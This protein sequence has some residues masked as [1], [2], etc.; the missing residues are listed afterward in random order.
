MWI[1]CITL[2]RRTLLSWSIVCFHLLIG[3]VC[4]GDVR[5]ALSENSS[6]LNGG[7]LKSVETRFSAGLYGAQI[8]WVPET[9]TLCIE[10]QLC[11]F[12]KGYWIFPFT[13]VSIVIFFLFSFK[14]PLKWLTSWSNE[15]TS[16]CTPMNIL[17][18]LFFLSPMHVMT[19]HSWLRSF[20]FRYFNDQ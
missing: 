19:A 16:L 15:A 7:C 3:T 17:V 10:F 6:F 11:R 12:M 14:V 8:G 9:S 4:A 1:S 18:P 13:L 2:L 5:D 20:A